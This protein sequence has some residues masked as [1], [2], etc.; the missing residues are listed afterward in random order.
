MRHA[1]FAFAALTSAASP[2]LA[3]SPAIQCAQPSTAEVEGQLGRFIAALAT[4]NPDAVTALFAADA[5]LLP[6]L[7]NTPRT[8][9]A[10]IREYFVH[11]LAKAPS[12]HVDTTIVRSDCHSAERVGTWTWTLTDPSTH[13]T[14]QVRGRYSFIYRLDGGQWR[15][16][17][18]HSSLMPEAETKTAAR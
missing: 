8:T 18:L 15:I 3:R 7:S 13:A 17:H 2:A 4:R 14:S 1:V 6:T 16:D 10:T 11:F 12:V 9:P 5:V